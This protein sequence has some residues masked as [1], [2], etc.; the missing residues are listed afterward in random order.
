MMQNEPEFDAESSDRELLGSPVVQHSALFVF[1]LR[2]Q[3]SKIEF[4]AESSDREL[5]GRPVA[6]AMAVFVFHGRMS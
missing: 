5:L 3:C 4:D 6:R 1:Y 2:K